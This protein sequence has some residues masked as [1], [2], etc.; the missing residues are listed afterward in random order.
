[1]FLWVKLILDLLETSSSLNELNSNIDELP[2]DLEDMLVK[3][4]SER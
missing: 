3:F 1:M 2:K 4:Q